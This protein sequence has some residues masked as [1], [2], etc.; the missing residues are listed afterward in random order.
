MS[1]RE[2]LVAFGAE[3]RLSGVL[4]AAAPTSE[5]A[6]GLLL[7]N[8]GIVHRIGAHRLNVKLARRFAPQG[9]PSLR[10]DLS[11]LGDSAAAGAGAG[12][13]EQTMR[14][15]RAA[16]DALASAAG[17]ARFLIVGMC[18]GADN[19]YRA[20]LADERIA[21]LV[22]LDPYS[23]P[24]RR[25]Q[26]GRAARKALDPERWRRALARAVSPEIA[27]PPSPEADD[28]RPFPAR[29]AFGV[30]LE[31]L[32]ARGVEI[33]VLYTAFV[34]D[35][36]T[37]PAHFF[38]TFSEFDF[39]GRLEVGVDPGVDHTYTELAAQEALF[40]RIETWLEARGL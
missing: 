39:R 28:S 10:F 35:H 25:A 27:P 12:L 11:G 9:R 32:C 18:S 23:Y 13:E 40:A 29:A 17:V 1:T 3:N 36:L 2:K 16:A 24:N 37:R 26:I 8:A 38:E 7:F 15:I 20:A 4:I 33:L 14:D 22:L 19:G 31:R 21:G 30:D 6:A 5:N 34:R